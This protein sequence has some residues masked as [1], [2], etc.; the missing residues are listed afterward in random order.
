M[1]KKL[2]FLL[3]LIA[4]AVAL[5]PV[6]AQAQ[7]PVHK[8]TLTW[9]GSPDE[10]ANPTVFTNV[11]RA[12]G[13]CPAS[14][15]PAGATKIVSTLALIHTYVDAANLAIGVTQC[16]YVK[17]AITIAGVTTESPS[18]SNTAGGTTPLADA[19]GLAVVSN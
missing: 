4:L 15:L 18:G 5:V 1:K 10:G 7:A 6:Q 11:Y 16:Y 12:T 17:A 3:L 13:P 2:L 8:N 19:S 14:G 9:V